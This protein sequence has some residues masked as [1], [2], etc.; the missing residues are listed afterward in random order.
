MDA[1]PES[2]MQVGINWQYVGVEGGHG[3]QDVRGKQEINERSLGP[4]LVC[5]TKDER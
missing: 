4:M 2:Q 1:E 5:F 3:G